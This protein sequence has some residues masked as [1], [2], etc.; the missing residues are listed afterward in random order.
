MIALARLLLAAAALLLAYLVGER[1][2]A[3]AFAVSLAVDLAVRWNAAPAGVAS[4]AAELLTAA[5]VPLA[6]YWLRPDILRFEPLAFWT[7]VAATSVPLAYGFIKYGELAVHRTRAAW[8]AGLFLAAAALFLLMTGSAWPLRLAAIGLAA[9]V[10]EEI[11]V[12]TLLPEP[13]AD[14]RSLPDALRR[15]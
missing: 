10:L 11:A 7:V 1:P 6:L 14:V 4:R 8:L 2:F 13:R 3:A 12:I 5:T 9:A 15:N